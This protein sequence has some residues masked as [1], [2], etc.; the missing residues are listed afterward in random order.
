MPLNE[1]EMVVVLSDVTMPTGEVIKKGT[2]GFISKILIDAGKTYYSVSLNNTD[3]ANPIFTFEAG[4]IGSI[5]E[6]IF[7]L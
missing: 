5:E 1:L 6:N 2:Q 7:N 4:Q 3:F